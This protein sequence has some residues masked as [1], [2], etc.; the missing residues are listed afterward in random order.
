MPG[1]AISI[2]IGC[3]P[4]V[5]VL[6]HSP[7]SSSPAQAPN[8][9]ST[10]RSTTIPWTFGALAA[11][12]PASYVFSLS[13]GRFGARPLGVVT[14][15]AWS[16]H[17]RRAYPRQIFRKE[18]FFHGHDNQDQLVKIARVLG[19]QD[20]YAYLEKYAL[21]LDPHLNQTL[22]QY[23]FLQAWLSRAVVRVERTWT[24]RAHHHTFF[25]PQG[26]PAKEELDAICHAGEQAPRHAGGCRPH[27]QASALRPRRTLE[28]PEKI[29]S[30]HIAPLP[31]PLFLLFLHS[32]I[33]TPHHHHNH[34]NTGAPHGAGGHGTPVL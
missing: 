2:S 13:C 33:Q 5:P 23:V 1:F 24:P 30:G 14:R 25:F 26:P 10:R 22:A 19:T 16:S 12:S 31:F 11:S 17:A 4:A 15:G 21:R 32:G 3:F 8:C 27:G 20:L 9:S 6:S 28:E 18:P 7:L 34:H 29:C